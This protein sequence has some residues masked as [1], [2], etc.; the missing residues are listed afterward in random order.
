[1][2][3]ISTVSSLTD[4][5]GNGMSD[6]WEVEKGLNPDDSSDGVKYNLSTHYTNLEVYL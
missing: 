3:Y 4:S 1:M 6:E 2:K 5:D